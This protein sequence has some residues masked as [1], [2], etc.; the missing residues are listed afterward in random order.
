MDG[1]EALAA[2]AVVPGY[3]AHP[4]HR[5]QRERD[6]ERREARARGRVSPVPDEADRREG[7]PPDDRPV[8]HAAQRTTRSRRH[9]TRSHE[10]EP[11]VRMLTAEEITKG[12]ILIVDDAE[13]HVLLLRK[14]L[15][16]AGLPRGRDDDEPRRGRG[17]LQGVPARPGRARSAHE[18]DRRVPDPRSA[19]GARAARLV[20]PGADDDRAERSRRARCARSSAGR[21]TS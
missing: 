8:P 3:A 18:P 6:A 20:R 13:S 14:V 2:P 9:R 7:V 17:P 16:G 4:D 10:R 15:K 11:R 12:R 1:F 19:E 21:A 5:P